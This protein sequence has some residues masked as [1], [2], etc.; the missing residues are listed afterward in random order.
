MLREIYSTDPLTNIMTIIAHGGIKENWYIV[1]I[2]LIIVIIFNR[3]RRNS[4]S[5][6]E[7]A[8]VA[9]STAKRILFKRRQQVCNKYSASGAHRP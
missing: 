8:S 9:V 2:F 5:R 7:V 3:S 4:N 1:I 6:V